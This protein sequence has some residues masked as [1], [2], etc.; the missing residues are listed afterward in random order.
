M[1]KLRLTRSPLEKQ[2]THYETDEEFLMTKTLM[3]IFLIILCAYQEEWS[4]I[5]TPQSSIPLWFYETIKL[6]R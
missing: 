1:G 3:S 2:R 4:T 6:Q 5:E